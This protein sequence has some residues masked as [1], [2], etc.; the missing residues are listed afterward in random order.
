MAMRMLML[1]LV[2]VMVMVMMVVVVMVMVMMVVMM[3]VMATIRS[4]GSHW[5]AIWPMFLVSAVVRRQGGGQWWLWWWS[6]WPNDGDRD[7]EVSFR[8][9]MWE[10]GIYPWLWNNMFSPTKRRLAMLMLKIVMRLVMKMMACLNLQGCDICSE[11]ETTCFLQQ[12]GSEGQVMKVVL[13]AD[14]AEPT[15]YWC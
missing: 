13:K 14:T 15:H 2:V 8:E 1:M 10:G 3:V 12:S 11:Y 7:H 6:S 4:Q 5:V 9:N